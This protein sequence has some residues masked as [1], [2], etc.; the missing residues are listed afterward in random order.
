M[1]PSI[2]LLS[3]EE[4]VFSTSKH[5][6]APVRASVTAVLLLVGAFVIRLITPDGDGFVGFIAGLLDIARIGLIVTGLGWIAYN[7]IVWKTANFVVTNRRVIREEGLAAR[8]SSATMLSAVTDV[9]SRVS[10]LGARLGYGDLVIF[11][12]G[13][14]AAA[15]RF[16]LISGPQQFRDQVM[17]AAD[18]PRRS[19]EADPTAVTD[20][21]PADHL[22][23]LS[24]LAELRDAGALSSEE[25]EAK[26]A[27]I[28]SRI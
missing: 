21:A 12:K 5:W 6:L 23:T 2:D 19:P 1:S 9:Q 11:G 3:G 20:S 28:L 27:E 25:F 22:A 16:L 10:F 14:E 13:G 26:K 17:D 24:R 15:D 7:V 18:S 8:R 4:I